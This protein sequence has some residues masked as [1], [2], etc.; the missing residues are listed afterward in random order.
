MVL[1]LRL[2]SSHQL[3]CASVSL[4]LYVLP[5]PLAHAETDQKMQMMQIRAKNI[6]R[7]RAEQSNGG[8]SIYHASACMYEDAGSSCLISNHD[9]ILTFSFPGGAPGWQQASPGKPTV[10]TAVTV[11]PDERGSYINNVRLNW[12]SAPTLQ[13]SLQK[14]YRYLTNEER[15]GGVRRTFWTKELNGGGVSEQEQAQ[16]LQEWAGASTAPWANSR[17]RSAAC[18]YCPT[19]PTCATTA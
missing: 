9:G 14:R 6:A 19:R 13:T 1:R 16:W 18:S 7:I 4:L 17:A 15:R 8:P 5:M 11:Y 2:I 10:W 12:D 3:A